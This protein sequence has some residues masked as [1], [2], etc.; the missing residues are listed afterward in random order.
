MKKY[1]LIIDYLLITIFTFIILS[2]IIDI[3]FIKIIQLIFF[4]L[5][6]IHIIQHRKIIFFPYEYK[7]IIIFS[8]YFY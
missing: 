2:K 4:I 1:T 8:Y 3:Q 6:S 5:I 7:N